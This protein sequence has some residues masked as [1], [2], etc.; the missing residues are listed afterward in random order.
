VVFPLSSLT[1]RIRTVGGRLVRRLGL[2]PGGEPD[3]LGE[4]GR[5]SGVRLSERVVVFFPEPPGN[6]YQLE[7]W[8]PPL[9]AL[10]ERQG[11]V[12]IT[13]DSRTTA[14]LRDRGLPVLCVARTATLDALLGRS[15]VG[16]ALYVSHH[17]RNFQMLR[18]S[19]VAHVYIGHGESDKAVSASNQLK[20]Y[21]RVFVAGRAA[22]ERV[23]A[24]LLWFDAARFVRVGRPQVPALPPRPVPAV[25]TVLYAPTWEGAQAS[26]SYSSVATHGADLVRSLAEA[27]FRVEYRPHPRTGANRGDIA[28][29]DAALRRVVESDPVRATGSR[30]AA[31]RPLEE[32]FADADLLVTDVSS[33]AVEWLGL[34]RPLV[35]TVPVEPLA[36]LGASPL[37][38]AVP[39]LE[40]GDAAKAGELAWRCLRE[41]PDAEAR[42]GLVDLYL[43]GLDARQ[44]LERFLEA[45]DEVVAARDAELARTTRIAP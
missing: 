3:G 30:V 45:C 33:L 40:A 31:D 34:G 6:T 11:V 19:S 38:A 26:M 24:E 17:P 35:V 2:V 9:R 32:A 18:F 36:V 16:L 13:Q 7:Q 22:E 14:R 8:L 39:R 20:A 41:D 5:L 42:A 27:G 12:V 28:A 10:S 15:D 4:D 21:D 25:P 44:A 37:L 29:A 23:L 1:R 43:G